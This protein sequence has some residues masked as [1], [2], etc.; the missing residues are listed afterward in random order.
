[1]S[2]SSSSTDV[3]SAAGKAAEKARAAKVKAE[4]NARKGHGSPGKIPSKGTA[5]DLSLNA[6]GSD[7]SV[8]PHI[9]RERPVEIPP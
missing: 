1:M 5:M 7:G 9:K 6:G 4:A 3:R 2:A 8:A